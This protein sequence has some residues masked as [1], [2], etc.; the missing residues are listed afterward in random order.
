MN[1]KQCG[2]ATCTAREARNKKKRWRGRTHETAWTGAYVAKQAWLDCCAASLA[3]SQACTARAK[4]KNSS[5]AAELAHLRCMACLMEASITSVRLDDANRF[6]LQAR[7]L[8]DRWR[9]GWP[10]E[11]A[12]G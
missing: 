7:I 6:A 8:V 5:D 3:A 4:A 12:D 9:A 10:Q 1:C 2:D 11:E